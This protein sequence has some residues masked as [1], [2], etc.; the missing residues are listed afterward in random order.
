MIIL[1]TMRFYQNQTVGNMSKN[2]ESFC[3]IQ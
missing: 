1:F 3:V 2:I